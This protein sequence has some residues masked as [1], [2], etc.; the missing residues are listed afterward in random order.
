[1]TPALPRVTYSNTAA[2][3]TPLHDWLDQA[4]RAFRLD[5]L[6]RAWPNIV[7][8]R[9]D[10]S[11]RAY[12]VH[13]PFDREILVSRL[14][15]ADK[16]TV[17]AAIEAARAAFPGWSE[18]AYP[19][20]IK[21][22]RQFA[23]ELE[24]RKY[25]LGMA[26]MFE[27]GKSR[28]EAV[29]EAEEAFDLIDWYCDEMERGR[30]FERPMNRAVPQEETV[31]RLRPVGT[32]AVIAPFNFPVALA[33]NMLGACLMAGNTAV[34]KPSP[35]AGLTG[36]LIVEAA[37]AA[38]LPD[39]VINFVCGET[40]G[41]MLV[42]SAGLDGVAFTGS[43]EVG[44][45]IF[46]KFA[47]ASHMR[48][49]IAEMGGKN[50]AYVT[51]LA[52]LDQ[53][54]EGVAR[55]AFG[56]SGEK[57]SACSVVHVDRRI[58]TEFLDLLRNKTQAMKIGTPEDRAAFI[59]PVI[60]EAAVERFEAIVRSARQVG[61]IVHGGNRV[62][63]GPLARG[64]FVEPTIVA[65]L[66]CEHWL[67][68]EEVFLPFLSVQVFERLE[69]AL[70][71][72]NSVNYGLTAGLYSADPDDIELFKT[73]AQAGVLYV[74][75]RSGATTGAWPGYQSFCGWKGSGVDG[76]GGLGPWTIPRYM[77]EQSL[78]VMHAQ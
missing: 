47:S 17:K 60:D 6:G 65:D 48:P 26:A 16:K 23:R 54:A 53:A 56:L 70:A 45:K 11:G 15:E 50:P 57:C 14:V 37:K 9:Q 63:S 21:A 71:L 78:T 7:G 61:R 66:P 25:Q 30:G 28:L 19:E 33:C 58:E 12:E 36:S 76:K 8:G 34:F 4:M 75:R 20:R 49:V 51:A 46:R 41:E 27:V 18:L 31:C 52:D 43:H 68:R 42:D 44:M 2:D 74:N 29:G 62:R 13:C 64:L 1:M 35:G 24:R 38:G 72:G 39:G 55:S 40:T 59:G 32:F 73:K 5:V 69:Y 3:F 77:R 10:V 67:N 22:M